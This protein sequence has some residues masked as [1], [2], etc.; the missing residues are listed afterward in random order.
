MFSLLR[1]FI[2]PVDVT[3]QQSKLLFEMKRTTVNSAHDMNE[4]VCCAW[5]N[6]LSSI[7]RGPNAKSFVFFVDNSHCGVTWFRNEWMH[8][9][10]ARQLVRSFVYLSAGCWTAFSLT[11][12]QVT[13]ERSQTYKTCLYLLA[14]PE[15][16]P[17]HYCVACIL[18]V[19]P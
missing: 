2:F 14:M 5:K 13:D 12:L 11:L 4:H 10:A 19:N 17:L 6:V 18:E 3:T 7:F 8:V 9:V 1:W 16:N 15:W